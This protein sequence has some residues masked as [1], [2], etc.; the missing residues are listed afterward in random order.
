M[1]MKYRKKFKPIKADT[2]QS[3]TNRKKPTEN[4]MRELWDVMK[5]CMLGC[6]VPAQC[7]N[8]QKD[9]LLAQL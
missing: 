7:Y 3:E 8:L 6:V 4:I 2:D 1:H 5:H 9:H